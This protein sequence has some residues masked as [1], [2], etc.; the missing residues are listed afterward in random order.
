MGPPRFDV[1]KALAL[2]AEMEDE[3][4]IEKLARQK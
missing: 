2:A 4:I 3:S 1:T